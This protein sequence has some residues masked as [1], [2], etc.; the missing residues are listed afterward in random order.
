[1]TLG[2]RVDLSDRVDLRS[3]DPERRAKVIET[4][5][6]RRRVFNLGPSESGT[7]V[8][9]RAIREKMTALSLSDDK[10]RERFKLAVK[11]YYWL[12][13][14]PWGEGVTRACDAFQAK[15][16]AERFR[17]ATIWAESHVF[18]LWT[19]LASRGIPAQFDPDQF[20]QF[21]SKLHRGS[22]DKIF[23]KEDFTEA[24]HYLNSLS[25]WASFD[26]VIQH[27]SGYAD[28]RGQ[29][30]ELFQSGALQPVPPNVH[31]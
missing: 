4:D 31:F 28:N 11:A 12:L 16:K 1:M 6:L 23:I 24:F 10:L 22:R 21:W 8:S 15:L 3:S 9:E 29:G 27:Y 18:Q 26:I 13:G 20:A 19:D 17:G 5:Q 2:D 30:D 25:V 14:E 7:L